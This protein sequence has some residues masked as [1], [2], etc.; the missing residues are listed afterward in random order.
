MRRQGRIDRD[1][2]IPQLLFEFRTVC[3]LAG[4]LLFDRFHL[5]AERGGRVAILSQLRSQ[6]TL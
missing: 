2:R 3:D 1:A 6:F 5:P 4:Q